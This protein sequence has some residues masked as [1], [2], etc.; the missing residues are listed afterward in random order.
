MDPHSLRRVG[1][2][3]CGLERIHNLSVWK[4]VV[5]CYIHPSQAMK[6]GHENT[7]SL[8]KLTHANF[9]CTWLISVKHL[10]RLQSLS[11]TFWEQC[12][13]KTATKGVIK[14]LANVLDIGEVPGQIVHPESVITGHIR[15]NAFNKCYLSGH[16]PN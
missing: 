1:I 12:L 8:R 13:D 10:W 14:C 6:C 16:K 9:C 15:I 4:I 3:L 2:I 7:R 5:C 11:F